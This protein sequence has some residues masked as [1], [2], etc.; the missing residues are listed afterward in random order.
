MDKPEQKFVQPFLDNKMFYHGKN[1]LIVPHAL[2]ISE[3]VYF[4]ALVLY[5]RIISFTFNILKH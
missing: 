5:I 2:T 1:V 4:L 3:K